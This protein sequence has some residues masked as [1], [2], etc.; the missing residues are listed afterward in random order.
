MSQKYTLNAN[1]PERE[2]VRAN[3][4]AFVD[5]LP[6]GKSWRIEI[7]EARKERTDVQNRALFGV[8]YPAIKAVTGDDIDDLHES[9]CGKF[10]GW[11]DREVMGEVRRRPFR[12]TTTNENGERDVM[13]TAEFAEF[14]NTV[15][16]I[17]ASAGIDV[18]SPDPFWSEQ[19]RA[20]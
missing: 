4:H 19:A 13:P 7:K 2:T 6:A 11:V 16:R 12:T 8:A 14:Y 15:Q 3:V 9:F 10:F 1:A 5:R 20:A 18:P 17:A